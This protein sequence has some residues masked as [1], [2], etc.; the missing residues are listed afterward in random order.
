MT[1]VVLMVSAPAFSRCWVER[2]RAV[3]CIF[4][5]CCA[6]RLLG[7]GTDSLLLVSVLG[8]A[9]LEQ[10]ATLFGMRMTSIG[11]QGVPVRARARVSRQD[12]KTRDLRL[13][14]LVL[15]RGCCLPGG[16]GVK[17]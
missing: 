14:V 4:L 5:L 17:R 13:A 6:A 15:W 1:A 2:H 9:L 16:V 3:L 12:R 10:G 8:A 7:Q 11:L